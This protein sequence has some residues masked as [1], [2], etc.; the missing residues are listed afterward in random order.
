MLLV[1]VPHVCERQAC[2]IKDLFLRRAHNSLP[3]KENDTTVICCKTFIIIIVKACRCMNVSQL[4][5]NDG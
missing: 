2:K 4:D 5:L 1:V 3:R